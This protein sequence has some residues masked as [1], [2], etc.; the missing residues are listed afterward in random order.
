M[1]DKWLKIPA[2]YYLRLTAFVIL[3]VGICL[4]NTLMSIGAIWVISNWLIEADFKNY[5]QKFKQSPTIWFLL[6]ILV[7]GLFSL[8]WS[9]DVAYGAK[10]L[11]RKMP[12]FAIPFAV[13]LGK[14]VEKKII[15][16]LLYVFIGILLLTS[17]INYYRFFHV[18]EGQHDLR[19]MS[20]FIS[21]VRFSVVV[22][23][24]VFASIYL[25]IKRKGPKVL[26]VISIIWL[27][28]YTFQAQI[29]NGY[30]I[31]VV[32]LIFSI[33]YLFK[34]LKSVKWKV[35]VA[36]GSLLVAFS[37]V[38]VLSSIISTY[39]SHE[40]VKLEDLDLLTEN[41]RPYLHELEMR[42]RENGHLV[43]IYLQQEEVESEWNKRSKFE[44]MSKDEHEQ[45][46]FGNI[47][48]YMTSMNL[49]KDSVGVWALSETDIQKIENG[50]TSIQNKLTF[51][52]KV[53][54]FMHQ[55]ELYESGGDPNNHSLLQRLEHLKIAKA[56]VQDHFFFG[57]GIG[58]VPAVFNQQYEHSGSQ[59]QDQRRMRSHNQYLTIWISHGILGPILL[60]GMLI[61]PL[62]KRKSKDY[63]HWVIFLT[64]LFSLFFQ[65]MLETQA[66]V[67]IFGFFY[68]LTVYKEDESSRNSEIKSVS[69]D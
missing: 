20:Y 17:S 27:S 4:H 43:W 13:G 18:L 1:F 25:L 64:L 11:G 30:V 39:S 24:G 9:D 31:F 44:Y 40:E 66:G 58:D 19:E 49:R 51:T 60:L 63:F 62:F 14:P 10:D 56:I 67:S 22:V 3:T 37:A 54:E 48:R 42:Q 16:F 32:L 52:A 15:Y 5:W 2:H 53:H 68:A 41:G 8:L 69:E 21:H 34:K 65:D 29:L 50:A 35:I 47:I 23:I 38:W 45:P 36:S 57:V 55:Y 46:M 26:W 12:F 59:L 33:G 7:L 28:Y 6:G 61:F